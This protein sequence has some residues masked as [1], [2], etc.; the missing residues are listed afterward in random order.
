[1][2]PNIHPNK[3][4]PQLLVIFALRPR[5]G[6][7]RPKCVNLLWSLHKLR[8]CINQCL[9][10]HIASSGWSG[11]Q[12]H[13]VTSVAVCIYDVYYIAYTHGAERNRE[14]STAETGVT[15][16]LG[17]REMYSIHYRLCALFDDV[18]GTMPSFHEPSIGDYFNAS[19]GW[20]LWCHCQRAICVGV[21]P[22][23]PC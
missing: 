13:I 12:R 11:E 5:Y 8:T 14:F 4:R 22:S 2:H 3:T 18:R 15:Q 7:G 9:H 6:L 17:L 10:H 20:R 21:S 23:G 19:W 1:M 16:P